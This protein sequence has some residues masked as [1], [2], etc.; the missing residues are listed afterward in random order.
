M[1]P[2]DSRFIKRVRSRDK[3]V[4]M[5]DLD[6]IKMVLFVFYMTLF[7]NSCYCVN[8]WHVS[9]VDDIENFESYH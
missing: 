6:F 7:S 9:L 3:G 5:S 4:N 8:P 2:L 1:N